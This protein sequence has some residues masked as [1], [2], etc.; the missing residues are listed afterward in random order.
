MTVLVFTA[1]IA[2]EHVPD[3]EAAG[4]RVF[5]AVHAAA[6]AGFRYSTCRLGDGTYLTLLEIPDG[7]PNP[8]P[9]MPEYQA[10]LRGLK[11]WL[12]EPSTG[13]PSTVIG[14]YRV[15]GSD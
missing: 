15:F 12:A 7:E 14:S 13:G 10:F 8:L 3:V 5:A 2:P 1:T 9:A 4:R 6:P 11:T